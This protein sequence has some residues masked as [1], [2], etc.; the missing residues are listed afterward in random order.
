MP[1]TGE[2]VR[3]PPLQP[4]PPCPPLFPPSPSPPPSPPSPR[5]PQLLAL[6]HSGAPS[7]ATLAYLAQHAHIL[8]MLLNLGCVFG[9]QH[10]AAAEVARADP[11][12]LA[13][14]AGIDAAA[15]AP[16]LV[17]GATSPQ[18]LDKALAAAC[19]EPLALLFPPA[20]A[21]AAGAYPRYA[22]W[23]AATFTAPDF[24]RDREA[25]GQ[26]TGGCVRVG[27]QLDVRSL[28]ERVSRAADASVERNAGQKKAQSQRAGE[29]AAKEAAAGGGAKAA[30]AAAAPAAAAAAPPRAAEQAPEAV[31]RNRALTA[32]GTEERI[33]AALAAAAGAGVALGALHRHA[34]AFKVPELEAALAGVRGVRCK[35]LFL[36]AK[37]ERAPGDSRLW[38][39]VADCASETDLNTIGKALGYAKDSVRFAD[40]GALKDN[41]GVLPGSVSPLCLLN[42][43][44]GC[45]NVVLDGS[46]EGKG[47]AGGGTPLLFHPGSNEASVEVAYAQLH[48]L[49]VG[50][51][52]T[53]VVM[54]FKEAAAK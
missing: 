40:E 29:D 6:A 11:H 17:P 19:Y 54:A 50:S 13:L 12:L 8:R 42:D 5:T 16:S 46:L 15:P 26:A 9:P 24:A 30:P 27:G 28:P 41:L 38:L 2:E 35:N 14:V 25:A 32:L 3:P 53:P 49:L 23:A 48:K 34:A 33:A 21:L 37:K 20:G 31:E 7:P 44:S 22:A 1:S 18:A 36:K 52:H 51:G 45:V 10:A 39:V 47:A 4:P 43:A